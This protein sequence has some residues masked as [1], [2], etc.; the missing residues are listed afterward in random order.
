M[1]YTSFQSIDELQAALAAHAYIADR[2]LTTAIFL[3]LKLNKPLLLEGEAGVG[4]TEIAKTLARMQGRE[5]I[6]LQCYEGLDVNTTIYE[7]NYARQML[8]IRLLEA[9]GAAQN[10]A[11]QQSIFGPEFLIKR[12]LLQAIEARG[13]QPP[14]LLIDELDRADEEFEAF[15]LELLSDWQISIPEIGTI[16]AEVPPTVIITSNRTREVH[17]A[18]KR[19]CL[20]YWVDYPTLDKEIQIVKARVPGASERLARQVVLV[21]Q[22]LRRMDLYKL[23]GV[24]ETLDWVTALV[25]LD[26]T[27]LTPQAVEDTLG[28]IL[29]Y[30][31]DIAQVRGQRLNEL[32]KRASV[33][34]S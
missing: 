13:D 27:E 30:Q 20:F 9:Q 3:A 1:T 31:D 11:A 8:Q 24:A 18:L 15:L 26:Q 25:A 7:W 22:E 34:V 32:L 2:A 4:K 14:I 17:D 29:K 23:P 16:R 28:A 12:P 5:L 10:T 6:R 21:V 33:G 19:R